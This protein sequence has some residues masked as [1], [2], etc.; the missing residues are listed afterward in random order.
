[1]NVTV[2]VFLCDNIHTG[3][4][5]YYDVAYQFTITLVYSSLVYELFL[6]NSV[7]DYASYVLQYSY[8]TGISSS[9]V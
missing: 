3:N 4:T 1:M 5:K 8:I 6:S 2:S 7:Y 9:Y